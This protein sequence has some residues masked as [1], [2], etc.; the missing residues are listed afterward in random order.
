MRTTLTEDEI[1]NF[2]FNEFTKEEL[3]LLERF[4]LIEGNLIKISPSLLYVNF[5]LY[6]NLYDLFSPYKVRKK[7]ELS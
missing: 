7:R 5:S 6:E 4:V 1:R 3:N 2:I